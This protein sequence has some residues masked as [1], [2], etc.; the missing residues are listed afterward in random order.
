MAKHTL[1]ILRCEHRKI[2]EVCLA[3]FQHYEK[4]L[5]KSRNFF[6]TNNCHGVIISLIGMFDL[7][8]LDP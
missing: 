2:F 5:N 4:G 6:K 7:D 3:I 1:K 8:L